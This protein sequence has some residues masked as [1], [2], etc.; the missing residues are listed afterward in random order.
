MLA[1]LRSIDFF[2]EKKPLGCI[3]LEVMACVIFRCAMAWVVLR[4]IDSD[5]FFKKK[6][7]S[8]VLGFAIFS[9]S[10]VKPGGI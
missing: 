5:A 7:L 1:V 10:M 9:A 8:D 6:K 3:L 2:F 4:F